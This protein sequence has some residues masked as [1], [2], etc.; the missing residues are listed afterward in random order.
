MA[1]VPQDKKVKMS[2]INAYIKNN[3]GKIQGLLAEEADQSGK[4]DATY[5]SGLKSE[6]ESIQADTIKMLRWL[7]VNESYTVPPAFSDA[8]VDAIDPFIRQ[9]DDGL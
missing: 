9:K 2:K 4:Y 5:Q 3:A 8:E 6:I 1:L 7:A